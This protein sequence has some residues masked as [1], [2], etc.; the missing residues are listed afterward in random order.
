MC[1]VRITSLKGWEDERWT[2]NESFGDN[3]IYLNE[4]NP[5]NHKKQTLAY[6]RFE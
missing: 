2:T 4:T 1:D 3:N 6:S 5:V